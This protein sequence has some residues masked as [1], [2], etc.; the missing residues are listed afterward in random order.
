MNVL[1][2]EEKQIDDMIL[3]ERVRDQSRKKEQNVSLADREELAE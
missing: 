2:K 1:L 3:N